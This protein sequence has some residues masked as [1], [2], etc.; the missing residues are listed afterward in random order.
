MRTVAKYCFPLV[1]YGT[2][3]LF[4]TKIVSSKILS[5]LIP[6]IF[7]VFC[8]I[9]YINDLQKQVKWGGIIEYQFNGRS[10]DCVVNVRD[11]FFMESK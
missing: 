9:Q 7:N 1:G 3:F 11:T 5:I 6:S 2:N 4:K 8:K 10:V